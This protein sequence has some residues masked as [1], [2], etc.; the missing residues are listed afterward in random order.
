MVGCVR[1]LQQGRRG[2]GG[3][4]SRRRRGTMPTVEELYRNYGI[5]ADAKETAPEVGFSPTSPPLPP[6]GFGL[7]PSGAE[8]GSEA[9]GS[10]FSC[11]ERW[12]SAGPKRFLEAVPSAA[13]TRKRRVERPKA[14][15]SPS[16]SGRFVFSQSRFHCQ[17]IRRPGAFGGLFP[18]GAWWRLRL[19]FSSRALSPVVP[20]G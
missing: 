4:R 7:W 20:G 8:K 16:L 3:Q 19:L 11:G 13:E 1:R 6:V 9:L 17:F 14:A 5:L 18:R 15:G 10:P 2:G 12:G